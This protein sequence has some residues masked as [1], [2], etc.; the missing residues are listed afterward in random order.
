VN[1]VDTLDSLY[2]IL[3]IK[4]ELLF[5]SSDCSLSQVRDLDTLVTLYDIRER[6]REMLFYFLVPNATRDLPN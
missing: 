5:Y 2:D 6:K 4:R 3:G 1:V